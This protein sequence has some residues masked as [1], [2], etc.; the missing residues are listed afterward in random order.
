MQGDH[1]SWRKLVKS[2]LYFK[3]IILAARWKR[4]YQGKRIEPKR[5]NEIFED[6]ITWHQ[7]KL[8]A[9]KMKLAFCVFRR[10]FRIGEMRGVSKWEA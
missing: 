2:D 4:D 10:G 8:L 6:Y 1:R 3:K 5:Q 7:A 9:A